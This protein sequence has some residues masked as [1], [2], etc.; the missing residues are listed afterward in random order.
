MLRFKDKAGKVKMV[1]H[2]EATEPVDI[3]KLVIED[4]RTKKQEEEKEESE[5]G[6]N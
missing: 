2:D 1:L 5:N 4:I 3:D 6:T